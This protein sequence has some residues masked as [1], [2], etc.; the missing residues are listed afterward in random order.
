MIFNSQDQQ[1]ST[2]HTYTTLRDQDTFENEFPCLKS[3]S[4]GGEQKPKKRT[5]E[6]KSRTVDDL[7]EAARKVLNTRAT[8]SSQHITSRSCR[9]AFSLNE[10]L[11]KGLQSD[12]SKALLKKPEEIHDSNNNLK[13]YNPESDWVQEDI[14]PCSP[15][16]CGKVTHFLPPFVVVLLD[17]GESAMF[18]AKGDLP[19]IALGTQVEC[20]VRINPLESNQVDNYDLR[21]YKSK[22]FKWLIDYMIVNEQRIHSKYNMLDNR[23]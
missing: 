22:H 4:F 12:G 11:P 10:F 2:G 9:P 7:F 5:E 6:R 8:E 3:H 14:I 19:N 15:F 16:D 17:S 21:L 1:Q 13:P 20:A 23:K 18:E